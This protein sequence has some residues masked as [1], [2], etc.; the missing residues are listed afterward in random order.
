VT[1]NR[2]LCMQMYFSKELLKTLKYD[3]KLEMKL[4]KLDAKTKKIKEKK[5]ALISKLD[6]EEHRQPKNP[7]LFIDS[8]GF[9]HLEIDE[10]A[11]DEGRQA[12]G[13]VGKV[14]SVKQDDTA[15]KHP[16]IALDVDGVPLMNACLA[17][18]ADTATLQQMVGGEVYL[19]KWEVMNNGK[20]PWTSKVGPPTLVFV[21]RKLFLPIFR[22]NCV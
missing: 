18:G 15:N 14:R 9:A 6:N 7:F 21:S 8:E 2:I 17:P 5:Q 4:D 16:Q 22:L 20:L 13:P 12:K 19:H 1:L 3:R 10:E 11:K